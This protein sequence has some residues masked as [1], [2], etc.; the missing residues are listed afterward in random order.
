MF[1]ENINL[2]TQVGLFHFI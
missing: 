2:E 1:V